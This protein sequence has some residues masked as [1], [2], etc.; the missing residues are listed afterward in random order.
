VAPGAPHEP[1]S[2]S[3]D[4]YCTPP[5]SSRPST[6]EGSGRSGGRVTFAW[7][8]GAGRVCAELYTRV[9][10]RTLL[11]VRTEGSGW[12]RRR[13]P[14]SYAASGPAGIVRQRSRSTVPPGLRSTT[15]VPGGAA[16]VTYVH[17]DFVTPPCRLPAR[18]QSSPVRPTAAPGDWSCP[19]GL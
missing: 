16:S 12:V 13:V 11:S 6:R 7:T 1:P 2:H 10:A 15:P 19:D 4:P 3:A 9:G 17:A 14:H 5:T 18:S 8:S